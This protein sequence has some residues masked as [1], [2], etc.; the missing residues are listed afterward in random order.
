MGR[1]HSTWYKKQCP[2]GFGKVLTEAKRALDPAGIL[3]PGVIVDPL[4]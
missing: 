1:Y 4:R 3:N 2:E